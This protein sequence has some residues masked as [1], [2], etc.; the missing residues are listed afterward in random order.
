MKQQYNKHTTQHHFKVGDMG[1][2]CCSQP[3]WSGSS[4]VTKLIEPVNCKL[5]NSA[6][7]ETQAIH[8]N[9]LKPFH[10]RSPHLFQKSNPIPV[11]QV[12]AGTSLPTCDIF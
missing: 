8:V 7:K 10:P 11:P 9:Q 4:T 5:Q 1:V 3:N 6:G 12:E 2:L